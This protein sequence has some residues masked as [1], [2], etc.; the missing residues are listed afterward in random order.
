MLVF[1]RNGQVARALVAVAAERGLRCEALGRETLDLADPAIDV[2]AEASRWIRRLKPSLVINAAAYTAVDRAETE[3]DAAFRLNRDSPAALARACA[4]AGAPF[5][6]I[7]TDYVF[8]GR[9]GAPY[10]ESDPVNPLN[11]Y[12]ASKA[13]GEREVAAAAGR[14]TSLR[15]SWVYAAEGRNFVRTM[16]ELAANSNEVRVVADQRGRPTWAGTV[17]E[18]ALRA[19]EALAEGSLRVT[20]L[21]HIADDGDLTW[22]DF[23]DAVFESAKARGGPY[24]R[25]V[26]ISTA[27]RPTLAVRPADARL[28]LALVT[29]ALGWTPPSWRDRLDSCVQQI[30]KELDPG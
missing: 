12:G 23:A 17:A 30:L 21:L 20:P 22:A 29:S 10:R 5:V 7:S 2:R 1:G 3:V 15:T 13:A 24:A 14:S 8:D 11:V 9:G 18:A 25:V 4:D 26:R 28:D 19:G 27:E 16:L 6:H